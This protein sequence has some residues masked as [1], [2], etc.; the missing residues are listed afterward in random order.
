MAHLRFGLQGLMTTILA[1]GVWLALLRLEPQVTLFLSGAAATIHFTRRLVAIVRRQ[2]VQGTDRCD[3]LVLT[4]LILADLL[5]WA[6]LYIV[7][8]GPTLC[9]ATSGM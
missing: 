6:T 7:S 9:S 3:R 4:A 8:L 2:R 5:S 1:C